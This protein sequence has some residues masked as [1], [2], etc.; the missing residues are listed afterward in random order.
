MNEGTLPL[1]V[2]VGGA[3]ATGKTTLAG[4]LAD[5]LGLP[6][7]SKDLIK[8]SLMNSFAVIDIAMSER[9]GG[10]AWEL[11]F[12]I[13]GCL[14]DARMGFVVEGNFEARASDRLRRV[15]QQSR[16]VQVICRCSDSLG[17]ERYERRASAAGRHPG[18]MD[19]ARIL[20]GQRPVSD[21][22]PFALGIPV[23]VVDTT[24]DYHPG[25]RDVVAF[26]RDES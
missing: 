2:I 15:A 3:P 10:A 23:L 5:A 9:I 22:G 14:L 20:R 18:H 26:C 12:L 24:D 11:L 8:E 19:A 1:V 13:T 7:L 17:Q 21:F 6:L 16:A 25:L 4:P